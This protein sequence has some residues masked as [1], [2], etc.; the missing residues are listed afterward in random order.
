MQLQ[1]VH[2]QRFRY[3]L[4]N[5]D[6]FLFN[7]GDVLT[8]S[9]VPTMFKSIFLPQISYSWGLSLL[10]YCLFLISY[11]SNWEDHFIEIKSGLKWRV[12]LHLSKKRRPN[13][14]FW[15]RLYYNLRDTNHVLNHWRNKHFSHKYTLCR[16]RLHLAQYCMGMRL[17][18]K[19]IKHFRH[20]PVHRQTTD[21]S[22]KL[23]QKRVIEYFI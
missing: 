5:S 7:P 12:L 17:Q 6:S 20:F 11:C 10:H 8:Y 1:N 18:L 14:R 13:R 21:F 22:D 3:I 19:K 15:P 9:N 4:D 16:D 2:F 23:N